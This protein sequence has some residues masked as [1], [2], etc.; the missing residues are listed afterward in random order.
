MYYFSAPWWMVAD[1]VNS[2][3]FVSG[4]ELEGRLEKWS[5]KIV[6]VLIFKGCE[7]S[8]NLRG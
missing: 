6:G 2:A 8:P 5:Q 4:R 7:M 1:Y 3:L